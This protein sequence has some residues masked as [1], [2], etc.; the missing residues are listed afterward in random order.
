MASATT[1]T[2]TIAG[3]AASSATAIEVVNPATER[4]IGRVPDASEHD[5]EAAIAAARAAW[6]E[7]RAT[8]YSA[9]Q[10]ALAR[11]AGVLMD[12][13]DELQ[14]LLTVEQGKPLADALGEIHAAAW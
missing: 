14:A 13:A 9:R 6:P 5:L 12:H 11:I 2:M 1:F 10:A 8:S 3:S 4:V 7:W